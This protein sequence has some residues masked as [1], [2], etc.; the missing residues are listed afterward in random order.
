MLN[1]YNYTRESGVIYRMI[2]IDGD[3]IKTSA[4]F[5]DNFLDEM[6]QVVF[7]P[8]KVSLRAICYF[9][10]GRTYDFYLILKHIDLE[11]FRITK[12][13]CDG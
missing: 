6:F 2:S 13:V 3:F 9:H 5:I 1:S 4:E 8:G 11:K 7:A 12:M 10:N